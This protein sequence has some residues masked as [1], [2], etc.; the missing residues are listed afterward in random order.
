MSRKLVR[1][2]TPVRVPK[3]VRSQLSFDRVLRASAEI[4]IEEGYDGFTLPKVSKRSGV[5][6]G[7]I[8]ARIDSKDD[9]VHILGARMLEQ[10]TADHSQLMETARA[11]STLEELIPVLFIGFAEIQ[12]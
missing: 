2:T 8:Y 4:L 7:S 11:I 10:R 1:M 3:Q 9:L 5:S 12:R 6:T